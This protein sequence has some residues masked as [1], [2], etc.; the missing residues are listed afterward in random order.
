[1]SNFQRKYDVVIVGGGLS[2]L[3]SLV[4]LI[5]KGLK[6]LLIEKS[7]FIGGRAFSFRDPITNEIVDNGQ[8]VVVGACNNFMELIKEVGIEN[9]IITVKNFQVPVIKEGKISYLGS[10]YFGS[11][12]GLLFSILIYKHLS[13]IEKYYLLKALVK[14]NFLNLDSND[15]DNKNFR[16]WLEDNNQ[17]LNSIKCFWEIIIKPA[18]NDDLSHVDSREALF[19]IKRSF[20]ENKDLFLGIPNANL[21]ELWSFIEKR[22]ESS[23]S[24]IL[25]KESVEKII[26]TNNKSTSIILSNGKSIESNF[27]IVSATQNATLKLL[28]KSKIKINNYSN[29]NELENAP[30]LGIHFWF[31][32]PLMKERFMASANGKIQWVFNVSRNHKKQDN[33]IVI[34]QSA[35]WEWINKDKD[36]LKDIF[37][38]ELK[39]LFNY[40]NNKLEKYCIVKQPNATFRCVD[41]VYKKR[42][43]S[44]DINNLFL[45]GDWTDTSWP[46]TMESAVISGR[47]AANSILRTQNSN[48]IV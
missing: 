24:K 48:H 11:I 22:V 5:K 35:A 25:K 13:F 21:S 20:L 40:S 26:T 7:A 19:V 37:L 15:F 38:N 17:G 8:H 31:N 2:G 28:E 29:K 4:T 46:S 14:I 44:T 34:S 42:T 39:E 12:F 23:N 36:L 30:I 18:L 32:K 47:R 1:M 43:L 6:V 27:V 45:A 10:K 3:S 41:N 9:K 33:H 16:L